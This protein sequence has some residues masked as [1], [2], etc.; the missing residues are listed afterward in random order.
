MIELLNHL[1]FLIDYFFPYLREIHNSGKDAHR[2][3]YQRDKI[4]YGYMGLSEP[5][6]R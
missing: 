3:M 4:T 2:P 5:S 1:A 6:S